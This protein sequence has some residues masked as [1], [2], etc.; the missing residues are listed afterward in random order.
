MQHYHV[1]LQNEDEKL[2]TSEVKV[3]EIKIYIYIYIGLCFMSIVRIMEFL[4]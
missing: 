1:I 2:I 3:T 4:R